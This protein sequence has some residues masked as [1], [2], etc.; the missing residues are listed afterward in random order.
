MLTILY[1]D[2]SVMY[3]MLRR[4]ECRHHDYY[5]CRIHQMG[6]DDLQLRIVIKVIIVGCKLREYILFYS[7]LYVSL[8]LNVSAVADV[9]SF[10]LL[11]DIFRSL[12]QF[13]GC[14]QS[15]FGL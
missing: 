3:F 1:S 7:W 11:L 12:G 10:P 15:V 14:Q 9:L 5:S 2:W 4:M 8:E 6:L 13:D